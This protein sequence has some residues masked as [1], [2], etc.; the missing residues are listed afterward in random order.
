[1]HWQMEKIIEISKNNEYK[2]GNSLDYKYFS[3]HYKLMAI[4][5]RKQI[6]QENLDLKRQ[7]NFIDKLEEDEATM[8]LLLKNQ[9]K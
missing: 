3:K 2:S 8:F 5:L 1:M 6:E 4:D 7:I 9:K